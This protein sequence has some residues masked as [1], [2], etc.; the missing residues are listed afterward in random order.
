M[1]TLKTSTNS[2]RLDREITIEQY[3]AT[4]DDFGGE[5]LTWTTLAARW[6][7]VEWPAAH[8]GEGQ[9]AQQQTATE[10]IDITIRYEAAPTVEPKMRVFF[11]SKY[12]DIITVQ[13]VGR[14]RFIVM[15][16]EYKD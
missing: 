1:G 4:L 7:S 3:S 16:C 5:V 13:K 12:Y 6:A 14:Q 15:R 10:S 8:S 11:D 9:E 2:L